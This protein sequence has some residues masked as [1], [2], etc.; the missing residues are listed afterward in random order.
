[1][2]DDHAVLKAA[3]LAGPPDDLSQLELV[4]DE[5]LNRTADEE[6]RGGA[7]PGSAIAGLFQQGRQEGGGVVRSA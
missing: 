1:M 7:K 6:G 5:E 3:G 4:L 2:F